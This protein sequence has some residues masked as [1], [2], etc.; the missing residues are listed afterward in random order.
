MSLQRSQFKAIYSFLKPR[1]VPS[2]SESLRTGAPHPPN[3]QEP[4]QIIA[5]LHTLNG[6]EMPKYRGKYSTVL[7]KALRSLVKWALGVIKWAS[8]GRGRAGVCT[9][10]IPQLCSAGCSPPLSHGTDRLATSLKVRQP[11]G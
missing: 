7:S 5:G 8:G 11:G 10:H 3:T 4:N 2:P 6:S 1:A 9:W